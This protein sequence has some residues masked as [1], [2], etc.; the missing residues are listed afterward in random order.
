MKGRAFPRLGLDPDAALH[1]FDQ[2]AR[3]VQPEPGPPDAAGESRIEPVE[4]LE[5]PLLLVLRDAEPPV[6]DRKANTPIVLAEGDLDTASPRRVLDRILDQ[7]HE[8]LPEALLVADDLGCPLIRDHGELEL[9]GG[10]LPL[11]CND[12]LDEPTPV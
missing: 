1:P 4:L 11:E 10:R 3:D 7:V 6:R 5:D 9:G 2:L 12:L 8:H